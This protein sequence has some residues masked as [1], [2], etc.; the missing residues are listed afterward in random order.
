VRRTELKR[1]L[2][3]TY[4]RFNTGAYARQDPVCFARAYADPADAEVAGLVAALLAF[5]RVAQIM[6]SARDALDRLGPHPR[7]F[8]LRTSP[9]ALRDACGGF[10]HRTADA[11][12]LGSLLVGVRKVLQAH[13]SLEGCLHAHDQPGART[14]LP[15]LEGLAAELSRPGGAGH[16]VAD[17]R[18]GS[19]CKRWNLYLR[20]MVRRD[21]VDPGL[22]KGVSPAR[23]VVP[24]DAHMW[25]VCR[26]LGLTSRAT[27]NMKA[28]LEV[29]DGFRAVCPGDPVRYDFSL[30]HASVAGALPP[31]KP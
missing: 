31:V 15:G 11:G 9:Q 25:R 13:G 6:R 27:C 29:T 30:M 28:A 18:R 2:E 12:N 22:W 19:A 7:D 20:W 17:P 1:L 21:E 24:L 16:L 23:L 10:V 26:G 5:G 8:I 3:R 14:I 4:A